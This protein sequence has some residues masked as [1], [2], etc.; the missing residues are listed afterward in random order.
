MPAKEFAR[1][2]IKA[3]EVSDYN[4]RYAVAYLS[5]FFRTKRSSIERRIEEVI[6]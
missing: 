5:N 2:Y 3:M 4:K 1:Q 6:L